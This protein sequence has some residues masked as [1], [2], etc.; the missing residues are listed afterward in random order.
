[1][2]EICK[3]PE[4]AAEVTMMPIKKLG[5]DA[6]ILYSDI[7]NPVASLG[8]DFDIVKDVG[9]VIHTPF[10]QRRMLNVCVQLMWIRIY[11]TSLRRFAF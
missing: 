10:G 5:V 3:Q 6:A 11:R 2:L 9:P 7:M 8:I 1:M 4:L